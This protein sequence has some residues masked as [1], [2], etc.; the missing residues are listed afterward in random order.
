[1]FWRFLKTYLRFLDFLQGL[2]MLKMYTTH[3]MEI[4]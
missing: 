1:L 4:W 3:I 2:F